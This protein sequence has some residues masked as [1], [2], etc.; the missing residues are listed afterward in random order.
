MSKPERTV[1]PAVPR[2]GEVSNAG[3]KGG[4]GQL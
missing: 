3:L 2:V 1:W 4:S